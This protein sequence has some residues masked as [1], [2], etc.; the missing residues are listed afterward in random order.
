MGGIIAASLATAIARV[1][2]GSPADGTAL[3]RWTCALMS[4]MGNLKF[5]A[6]VAPDGYPR[7]IPILQA[8]PASRDRILF[9]PLVYRDEVEEIPPDRAAP[10]SA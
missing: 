10:Y 7:I 2:A 6:W 8:Q 4:A 5:A 3:N 9:S 1:G